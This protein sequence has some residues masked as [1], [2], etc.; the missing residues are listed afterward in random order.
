MQ[1]NNMFGGDPKPEDIAKAFYYY[2]ES[3]V[4]IL[5]GLGFR[6]LGAIN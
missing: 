1:C 5:T 4:D 2:V 3:G 6:N